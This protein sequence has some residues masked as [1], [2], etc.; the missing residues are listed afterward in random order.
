SGEQ[1]MRLLNNYLGLMTDII[2][3]HQGTIDEF[4][5]DAIFAL[6]GA[7]IAREDDA[8]RAAACAVAMQN[9]MEQVNA[10]NRGEG[11]PEVQMGIAVNTGDVIVG[12]IGSQS[13][14]KYGVVGSHVNL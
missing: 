13:R 11:M 1:V 3:A 6:F 5:G 12:N 7:P 8:A 2:L 10:Y 9:A 4:I 14:V